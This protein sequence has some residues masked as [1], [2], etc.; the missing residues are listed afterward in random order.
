MPE[1]PSQ[2]K[3]AGLEALAKVHFNREFT[4]AERN[5]LASAPLRYQAYAGPSADRKDPR[6]DPSKAEKSAGNP[7]WGGDREIAADLIRWLCVDRNARVQIDP[8]G[9]QIQAAKIADNF[10]LRRRPKAVK[11]RLRL[12]P[13]LAGGAAADDAALALGCKGS[14][15]SSA[16]TSSSVTTPISTVLVCGT[17]IYPPH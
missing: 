17:P 5:L 6:N 14:S 12:I 1:S 9:L 8:R 4:G 10:D 11:G 15:A 2:G 3:T 7:G 16:L 13:A